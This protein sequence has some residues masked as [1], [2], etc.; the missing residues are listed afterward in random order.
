VSGQIVTVTVPNAGSQST[1]GASAKKKGSSLSPG[2]IAGA[3]IGALIAFGLLVALI[4]WCCVRHARRAQ[5]FAED[6]FHNLHYEPTVPPPTFQG[7]LQSGSPSMAR[8]DS[9]QVNNPVALSK[10]SR[11]S[12]NPNRLSVPAFTDNRMK[13]DYLLYP[14][15]SR[16]SNVS[17][18]DHHDYS[19]P[20]LR[21][22]VH[23]MCAALI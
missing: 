10:N 9:G 3:V 16:H 18:Q 8:V 11:R 15:G 21:V 23:F 2:G 4:M 14:N 17:L 13:K 1:S 20:V 19:R 5:E 12:H 22:S 7:T 6:D